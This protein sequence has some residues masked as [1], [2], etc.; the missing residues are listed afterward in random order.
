LRLR[1]IHMRRP[2]FPKILKKKR[3]QPKSTQRPVKHLLRVRTTV[4]KVKSVRGRPM[5]QL[6]RP[7]PAGW[8]WE[9][10]QMLSQPVGGSARGPGA[11]TP[12]RSRERQA[13]P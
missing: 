13:P 8:S 11:Q 3:K 5:V 12:Q 4:K 7:R 6:P 1:K 2:L 10:F 9:N